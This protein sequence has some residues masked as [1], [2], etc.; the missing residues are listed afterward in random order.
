MP[1]TPLV[2]RDD[3][4]ATLGNALRRTKSGAGVVVMTGDAGVGKTR[5]LT[6]FGAT[7]PSRTGFLMGRGSARGRA[8]PFSLLVETL[9]PGLRRLPPERRA[10]LAEGR[11]RPLVGIAPA[12]GSGSATDVSAGRIAVLDAF[13]AALGSLAGDGALVVALDDVH[14]ADPSTR[15]VLDYLARNPPQ[16]PVLLVAAAR[17]EA[18]ATDPE[19]TAL[20]D[21]LLKDDLAQGLSLRPLSRAQIDDL[22]AGA[23]PPARLEAGL[24]DWLW[25]RARGNP[26]LT[27]ALIEELGDDPASREVPVGV[28]Q[29]AR[30]LAGP[31]GPEEREVLELAAVL[32]HSFALET[33]ATLVGGP[34]DERRLDDLVRGGLLTTRM[35]DGVVHYDFVHPLVQEA[36]YDAIGAAT[37]RRLHA[38]VAERS[39][40]EP[41]DVRAYHVARGA[42]PGDEDAVALLREAARHDEANGSH[43]EALVHLQAALRLLDPDDADGGAER[44]DLLREIAWQA[45]VA[46]DHTVGIPALAALE[47]L[48][49]ADPRELAALKRQLASFLATGAGDLDA[50]AEA[51]DEAVR[52]IAAGGLDDEFPKVMNELAWIKGEG[53]DLRAQI[54]GSGEAI[55]L[56]ERGG[57]TVTAMHARGAHAHALGLVGRTDEAE[58]ASRQALETARTSAQAD[59]IG[60]HAGALADS[61]MNGGRLAEARVELDTLL[62]DPNPSDVA[63]FSRARLNWHLGRWAQALSDCRAIQAMH[64][65]SPSI[66]SAWTLTLAGA[67]L[68]G[69][70]RQGEAGPLVRLAERVYGDREFYIFSANHRWAAG[71]ARWLTGDLDEASALMARACDRV[72]SMGAWPVLAQMLPDLIEVRIAIGELGRATTDMVLLDDAAERASDPLSD[73]GRLYA[74]GL[75]AHARSRPEEAEAVLRGALGAATELG[76]GLIEARAAERLGDVLGGEDRIAAWTHAGRRY[77][78]FPAHALEARVAGALRAEGGA[79]RRAAQTIG[80]LTVRE[81]EVAALA[82]RGLSVRQM[83]DDLHLSPR[84]IESHLA[85]IYR[86]LGVSGRDELVAT[87]RANHRMR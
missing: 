85:H 20:F 40:R 46:S 27:V 1:T 42:L 53:G 32:G 52:L 70:G 54:E 11:G 87:G 29:R 8:V 78:S 49:K 86:K 9:E 3:E 83:A 82:R 47:P 30:R 23:A 61:L 66:H 38:A 33:I 74:R 39:L 34:E 12:L 7:L 2:G 62:A 13:A 48:L 22:I 10:Q 79:G 50:A 45:G 37:R 57:D 64:P 44:I 41:I 63:Y 77:A 18:L 69:M 36:T 71:W 5:L 84:T 68:A 14:Q 58:A 25:E 80:A 24:A 15:E 81:R 16:A 59:Q 72:E 55:R 31:L 19:L 26:L 35:E 4:L 6:E 43:R 60:W 17:A 51:A 67:L 21:A 73:V 56:A 28:K 65:V 75:L 76:A